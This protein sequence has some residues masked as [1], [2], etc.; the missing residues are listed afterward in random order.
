MEITKI[1][2][3]EK[4]KDRVNVFVDGDYSFSLKDETCLKFR[5][6]KGMELTEDLIRE[7]TLDSDKNVATTL[8]V[9]Y[10]SKS[11]KTKKQIY[12]YL[13]GK[14]YSD[15]VVYAVVEKLKEYGYINDGEFAKR[16][17][18]S[19]SSTQGKKLVAFKL[20]SKGVS[21]D[22]IESAY[23]NANVAPRENAKNL[24]EKRLKNK[25]ITKESILKTYKYLLSK[26][27]S[28]DEA[29]YGISGLKEKINGKD[30]DD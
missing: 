26:G 25:E 27:F 11:L 2:V 30:F 18:E 12:T 13:K 20:M 8:A 9:K 16:Y 6:K 7:M 21:K 22:L 3:Q 1:S 15:N 4:K 14:G 28:F 24:A 17:I 19:T 29:E 5:L 10:V 23:E